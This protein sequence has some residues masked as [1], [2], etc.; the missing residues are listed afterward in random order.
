MSGQATLLCRLADLAATGAK[1]ITIGARPAVREIVVVLDG[2]VVR[3]YVNSCP[4][5]YS[6][7]EFI[8]DTFLDA[9][10]QDL[11]CTVHGATF[12][13][14]DGHCVSGPCKGDQLTKV[15]VE[16]RGDEVHLVDKRG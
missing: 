14:G 7:L 16:I 12:R 11:E 15:P 13:I 6:K 10:R 2:S 4:H 3:A 5:A 9:E 8:P 1:G